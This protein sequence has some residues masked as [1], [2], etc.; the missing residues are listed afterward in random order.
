MLLQK[1]QISILVTCHEGLLYDCIPWDLKPPGT[2]FILGL[3]DV[4]HKLSAVIRTR[5]GWVWRGNTTTVR[6]PNNQVGTF[7]KTEAVHDL[8]LL[9]ICSNGHLN[10][11]YPDTTLTAADNDVVWNSVKMF[12]ETS[13]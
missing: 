3:I 8:V 1:H 11:S 13:S 6:P 9:L 12:F 7:D 2:F 5:D 4:V 10:S